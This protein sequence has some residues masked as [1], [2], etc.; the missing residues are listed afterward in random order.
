ML[1]YQKIRNYIQDIVS[2]GQLAK[3]G[4]LP[5]ERE[6]Q[7][8][9]S[10]TRITVR[11]AL[12]RL[13]AEGLIYSQNRR[14]WFVSPARFKWHPAKKV[15]YYELA[16]EQGFEPKTQL[17]NFD[18]IQAPEPVAT[19]FGTAI[20]RQ[21]QH[22]CRVRYLDQR[23]VLIEDIYCLPERF[24][25]LQQW[26]L[27]GSV[28]SIMAEQYGVQ[29]THENSSITVTA[30]SDDQSGLLLKNSGAPCL[31]VI[32]Q[33]FDSN[34]VLVDYNIEYWLHNVIEMVVEGN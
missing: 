1:L 10:S 15:N 6:L 5:S 17:I 24:P 22:F 14:G 3:E 23:P 11:E 4:K 18:H 9:F 29:V 32:R 16:R 33:R 21:V 7:S 12:F 27:E 13:E 2:Q 19:A 31:K 34:N 20:T 25:E 26:D 28:T 30:L 8:H